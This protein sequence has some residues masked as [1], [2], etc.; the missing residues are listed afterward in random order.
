MGNPI[1]DKP[2]DSSVA[3]AI[4]TAMTDRHLSVYDLIQVAFAALDPATKALGPFVVD[5]V[6][7]RDLKRF[8]RKETRLTNFDRTAL[9]GFLRMFYP[10]KGP[11]VYPGDPTSLEGE[12]PKG[13]GQ[14]AAL[15][16]ETMMIGLTK[17]WREG[18]RVQGNGPLIQK[19]TAVATF[20]DGYYPNKDH[21]NHVAYYLDQD[22]SGVKV[23]DQWSGKDEVSSRVMKFKARRGD[24][25]YTDPSNNGSALSVIMT[26]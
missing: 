20:V 7:Y 9:E 25:L 18:I 17:T 11:F 22:P 23:M 4:K 1:F 5:D 16:Q 21:D 26:K 14:C 8:I 12:A 13:S 24:G 3:L 10:M 2:A 6:E 19:G 15:V